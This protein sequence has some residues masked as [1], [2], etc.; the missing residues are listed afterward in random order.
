MTATAIKVTTRPPSH[1]MVYKPVHDV[2]AAYQKARAIFV[3]DVAELL[4]RGDAG[5]DQALMDG[6]VLPLLYKP[7]VQGARHR[8]RRERARRR[9]ALLGPTRRRA[10]E[11]RTDAPA[12]RFQT[13]RRREGVLPNPAPSLRASPPPRSQ[14]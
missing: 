2:L 14:S 10:G 12:L 6:K 7:L 13:T 8:A 11:D 1:A 4:A 9:I 3:R 5:M